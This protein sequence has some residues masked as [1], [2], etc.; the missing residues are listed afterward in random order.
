MLTVSSADPHSPA[1]RPVLTATQAQRARQPW[2]AMVLSLAALLAIVAVVL[3]LNPEPPQRPREDRVDVAAEAAFDSELGLASDA[4]WLTTQLPKA[5]IL[6]RSDSRVV[7][8]RICAEGGGLAVLPLQVAEAS[9]GLVP[10]DLGEPPP[11]REIWAGYHRDFQ[12]HPKL[13]A[14]LDAVDATLASVTRTLR[15]PGP[16]PA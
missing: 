3:L 13:R 16:P 1:P 10:V 6:G 14:L 7:Q 8:A 9:S 2:M 11:R 5:R 4:A 12:R 15:K